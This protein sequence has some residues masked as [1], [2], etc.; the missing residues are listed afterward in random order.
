[1]TLLLPR[2]LETRRRGFQCALARGF[3]SGFER[4]IAGP[5]RGSDRAL[6]RAR[7]VQRGPELLRQPL[8]FRARC[9]RCA[10]CGRTCLLS[11]RA[12]AATCAPVVAV[13]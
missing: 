7:A 11:W 3:L 6:G 12:R 8:L 9:C 4:V 2:H 5:C 13:A 1:M 10:R